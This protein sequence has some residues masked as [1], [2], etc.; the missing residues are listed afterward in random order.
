M[1][2]ANMVV[3]VLATWLSSALFLGGSAVLADT[4]AH[5]HTLQELIDQALA[6]NGEIREVQWRVEGAAARLRQARAARILPRLRLSGEGGLV[7][8]AEGDIFNPP[9]DTTGIRPLGPFIRTE[10][11]AIQPLYTFGLISNLV[12]AAEGGLRVEQ[13]S[14]AAR[15]LDIALETQELYYRILQVQDLQ[16]LVRR[17]IEE[18]EKRRGELEDNVT[19][20]LSS[21]YKLRLALLE[22]NQQ[23][24]EIARQLKLARAALAWKVGFPQGQPLAL[25]ATKLEPVQ[26]EVPSL[27]SLLSRGL[28]SR[29]DWRKLQGGLRAKKA[30]RDAARSAFFPQIF[31]AGGIRYAVAPNRTDQHNPFVVDNYNFF[32]SGVFLGLR[33]SFEWGLLDADLDQARAAYRELRA[34]EGVALQGIRLDVERTH[35]NFQQ[36]EDGLDTARQARKLAQQ[37]L[38]LAVEEYELDPGEVKELVR[39][40]EAWAQREQNYYEAIYAFN[41]RVAELERALGGLSLTRE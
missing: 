9:K 12:R 24:R 32:S 15:R 27:D 33:Q 6:H 25:A 29:P 1:N 5:Q 13:A 35:A 23:E 31:L 17:L 37:W 39:A 41:M 36:A 10:L 40:F 18:I 19:A 26:A 8:E 16:D 28:T 22:L 7:P 34:K 14:L 21:V 11:E 20:P 2:T 4:P 30:L 3:F 38:K